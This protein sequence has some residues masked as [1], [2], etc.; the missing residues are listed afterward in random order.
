MSFRIVNGP[1]NSPLPQSWERAAT[2]NWRLFRGVAQDRLLRRAE[3]RSR[4]LL[5]TR[6][7]EEI[8]VLGAPQPHRV[9]EHEI[10]EIGFADVTI[11]D[12]LIRFGQRLAHVDDVEMPDIRAVDRVE[13]RIERVKL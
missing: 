1:K 6:A 3:H 9:L 12:Q 10:T 2:E 13:L 11:L 7:F 5:D 4:F 8:G